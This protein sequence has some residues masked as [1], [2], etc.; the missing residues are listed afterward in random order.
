MFAILLPYVNVEVVTLSFFQDHL[1]SLPDPAVLKRRLD[2]ATAKAES[3][4]KQAR[5][6]SDR[7]KRLR[8][9]LE[10]TLAELREKSMVTA[11]LKAQLAVYSG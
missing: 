2:E 6:T 5:N 10:S 3:L 11:E 4:Y 9:T 7:E 8:T 1:Y